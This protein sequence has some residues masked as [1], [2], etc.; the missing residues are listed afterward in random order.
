M[1]ESFHVTKSNRTFSLTI[2][3][4]ILF[5]IL[6]AN[7]QFLRFINAII[8]EIHYLLFRDP[9]CLVDFNYLFEIN[10]THHHFR[11]HFQ[12][13][14]YHLVD[15]SI[16]FYSKASFFRINQIPWLLSFR[17]KIFEKEISPF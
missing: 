4:S 1:D 13:Q 16:L 7:N 6:Q 8:Q 15:Y 2:L 10:L 9:S 12:S 3:F 17:I 5:E 11:L 14:N